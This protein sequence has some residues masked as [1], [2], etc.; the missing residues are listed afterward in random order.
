MPGRLFLTRPMAEVADWMDADPG[1]LAD[2]PRYNITPGQDVVV[3]GPSRRLEHMRWGVIPV[4]RVNARGR[5]VL[6]AIINAR[7]ESVFDKTAFAGVG[8]AL[9]PVDGWYEWTGKSRRKLA[10][11][12]KEKCGSLL[13]FAAITDVWV[14]PGGSEVAQTAAITCPPSDDVA[15]IHHR[16][17]VL[18]TPDQFD[19]WLTG[20][21]DDVKPLLQPFPAGRILGEPAEGVDWSAP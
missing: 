15:H 4:G 18:L 13:A 2:P 9:I 8:R 20:E 12:L 7:S 11:R 17:G 1:G 6:E 3:C 21:A 16:M 19:V 5:P 10:W 14:A